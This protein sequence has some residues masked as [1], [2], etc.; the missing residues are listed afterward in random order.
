M[1]TAT[2]GSTTTD[3]STTDRPLRTVAGIPTDHAAET[4]EQLEHRLVAML[5]LGLTIKHV[6]WNVYGPNFIA[7]HEMLDD[8]V[9]KVRPM[10]DAVAERIRTLGG[11]P[12]GVPGAITSGRDWADYPLDDAPTEDHLRALDDVFEGVLLDH[13]RAIA[14]VANTDPVTEDLLIGHTAELELMQWFVRSFLRGSQPDAGNRR[15]G[16]ADRLPSDEEIDAAERAGDIS[17][18]TAARYREMTKIGTSVEGG[19]R[20]T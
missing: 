15:F 13:R 11:V 17:A 9:D 1:S 7:V 4:I 12:R 6:H 20:I 5:D 3:R 2:N 8:F 18:D 16:I 10:S 14:H 19:G